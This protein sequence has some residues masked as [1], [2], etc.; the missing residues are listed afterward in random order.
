LEPKWFESR[1]GDLLI[2]H[3]NLIHGGSP[4]ADRYRS[5]KALVCH[6]NAQ[7]TICYHD[8]SGRIDLDR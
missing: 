7:N 1:K 6:Y 4:M 5:R 8:L 2:W 3:H